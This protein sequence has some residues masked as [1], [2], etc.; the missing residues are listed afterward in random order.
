VVGINPERYAF[1]GLYLD[2][3]FHPYIDIQFGPSTAQAVWDTGA[4]ITVVDLHFVQQ[5]PAYFRQV[6]ESTG[7]DSSG[8]QQITPLYSMS[9]AVIG[10]YVFPPHKVA[11]VDMSQVNATLPVP[12]DLIVGYST[13]SKA[14]W[15]FDFPG[16]RW[17]ITM[18]RK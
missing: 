4:S 2:A 15:L 10:G 13:F 11:G 17:A 1:E 3:T 6:G 7:T 9:E 18:L 5:Y 12:M 14:N 16:R 8:S